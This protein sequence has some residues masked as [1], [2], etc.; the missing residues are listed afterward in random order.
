MIR[1]NDKVMGQA[2]LH[3]IYNDTHKEPY[4]LFADIVVDENFRGKGLGSQLVR[5]VIEEAKKIGC[6]KLIAT[7]RIGKEE[8]R[9]WYEKFGF[10]NH[11]V[12]L[13]MDFM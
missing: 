2:Y 11:G 7:V 9:A 8:V 3:V 4:G 12:E 13:R 6:Y 1:D 5:A 10:K